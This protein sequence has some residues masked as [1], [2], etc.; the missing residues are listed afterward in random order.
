[1]L[2]LKQLREACKK[3]DHGLAGYYNGGE[4]FIND[5]QGKTVYNRSMEAA[6]ELCEDLGLELTEV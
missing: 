6:S 3:S 4:L 2:A 5:R 1:M